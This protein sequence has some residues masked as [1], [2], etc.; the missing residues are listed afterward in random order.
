MYSVFIVTARQ[1]S[2]REVMFSVERVCL[3]VG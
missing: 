3:P 1:Q 2:C